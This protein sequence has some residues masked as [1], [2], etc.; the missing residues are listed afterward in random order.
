M[1]AGGVG[2][3]VFWMTTYPVD[4]VKSRIQVNNQT[5]NFA[6]LTMTIFRKE[7]ISAL[8]NGLTPTLVRTVPATATLFVAY[9]YSKKFLNSVFRDF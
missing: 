8:Y 1:A 2:G 5:E 6:A 4:V 7:G 9:E 3:M